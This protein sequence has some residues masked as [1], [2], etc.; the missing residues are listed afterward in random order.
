MVTLNA[1]KYPEAFIKL[2]GQHG[3]PAYVLYTSINNLG[4]TEAGLTEVHLNTGS[5][6]LVKEEPEVILSLIQKAVLD[7]LLASALPEDTNHD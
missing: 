1:L 6:A 3:R 2:T 5:F 4:V 7:C